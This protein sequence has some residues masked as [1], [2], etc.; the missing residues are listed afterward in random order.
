MNQLSK[1]FLKKPQI[2]HNSK[3]PTKKESVKSLIS[4]NNIAYNKPSEKE[5]PLKEKNN[6]PKSIQ[7]SQTLIQLNEVSSPIKLEKDKEIMPEHLN[8]NISA[9]ANNNLE[10]DSP[11]KR[12]RNSHD[13]NFYVENSEI[14]ALKIPITQNKNESSPLKVYSRRGSKDNINYNNNSNHMNGKNSGN[15]I[16][17]PLL[18][19]IANSLNKET[20]LSNSSNHESFLFSEIRVKENKKVAK[21]PKEIKNRFN[22]PNFTSTYRLR[23]AT[24]SNNKH[25]A[26]FSLNS[27]VLIAKNI[28]YKIYYY[29]YYYIYSEKKNPTPINTIV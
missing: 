19:N 11:Q 22:S 28:M 24:A 14:Y 8:I 21:I 3:N 25:T 27:E 1:K 2:S 13:S 16:P 20:L 10:E 4:K 23:P 26:T 17:S 6:E 12:E 5:I 9:I 18:R 7:I 15:N 29:Y